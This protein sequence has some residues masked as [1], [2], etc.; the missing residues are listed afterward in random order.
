MRT[1]AKYLGLAGLALIC[2]L[3]AG[4][5]VSGTFVVWENI[6][7]D[8]T[9]QT[10]FYWWPV[11][12]RENAVWEDHS[13]DIDDIDALGFEFEVTNTSDQTSTL[14][15]SL[16][17]ATGDVDTL[18]VPTEIPKSAVLAYG[19]LTV[20]AGETKKISY[21]ES[22]SLIK[23]LDQIKTILLTGRFD[24]YGTSTGGPIGDFEVRDGKII[25]TI[26]ASSTT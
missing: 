21:G 18:D 25:V 3:A 11:D 12:L 22:L 7:F 6:N 17:A 16:A 13:E 24:Y 1:N 8:F 20:K 15:F 4:C 2:L 5:L 23:N 19:P 26:S 10:G 9:A 14:S